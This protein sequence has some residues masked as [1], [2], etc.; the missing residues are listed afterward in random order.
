MYRITLLDRLIINSLSKGN[1]D[2][3]SIQKDTDIDYRII[4]MVTQDLVIKNIIITMD[5]KLHIN[6]NINEEQAREINNSKDLNNEKIYVAKSLIHENKNFELKK[7]SLDNKNQILFEGMLKN[8][9]QFL[10][11]NKIKESKTKDEKLFI[12]GFGNYSQIV[13]DTIY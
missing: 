6:K 2:L 4:E 3:T 9:T 7:Y 10:D 5:N 8:I 13:K 11:C 1:N 12:F